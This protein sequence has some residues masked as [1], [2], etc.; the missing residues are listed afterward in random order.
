MFQNVSRTLSALHVHAWAVCD[1]C[2]HGLQTG[3]GRAR[4]LDWATLAGL[5]KMQNHVTGFEEVRC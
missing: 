3:T 2:V 1:A 4:Q 5:V